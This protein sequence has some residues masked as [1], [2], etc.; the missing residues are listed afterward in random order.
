[1]TRTA[2]IALAWL[3]GLC[4]AAAAA[5][6]RSA[7]PVAFVAEQVVLHVE[8]DSLRVD[9]VY[10]LV[11][12]QETAATQTTLA[13]P[14]PQDPLLGGARTFQLACRLGAG[15]W[16][17]LSWREMQNGLG[18]RWSLPVAAGD[19]LRVRTT[20]RQA[21]RTTYARYI[22]TTT[23]AWRQPLQIARFEI[24]LPVGAVPVEFSFPF[25]RCGEDEQAA[26]CYETTD[27]LPDRDIIVRWR[28]P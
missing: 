13:Y 18:A 26:W 9:A 7:P 1:M 3:L 23:S 19:T 8:P 6:Q 5:P 28:G 25:E 27:F 15:D 17:E 22:V 24:H 10:V 20:Y 14:Y 12:R 16:Q 2:S 11:C 4:V 21:L